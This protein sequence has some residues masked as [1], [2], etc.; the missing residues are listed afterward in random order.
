MKKQT[1][2]KGKATAA[3]KAAPAAP[4]S[5]Q[6]QPVKKPVA[7]KKPVFLCLSA[8]QPPRLLNVVWMFLFIGFVL[9]LTLFSNRYLC[10]NCTTKTCLLPT[11]P[12]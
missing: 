11:A 9:Q 7:G 4:V 5:K 6:R 2:S 10:G 1:P 12:T 8:P 3:H